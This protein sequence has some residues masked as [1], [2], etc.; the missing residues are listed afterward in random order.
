MP[1]NRPPESFRNA[2]LI[3]PD[4]IRKDWRE[5]LSIRPEWAQFAVPVEDGMWAVVVGKKHPIAIMIPSFE[6]ALLCEVTRFKAS[7][8]TNTNGSG[9]RAKTYV[10]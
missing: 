1:L 9:P 6:L 3:T 5:A 7:L 10:R 8:A 4:R 2:P